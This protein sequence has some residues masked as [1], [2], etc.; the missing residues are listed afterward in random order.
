MRCQYFHQSRFPTVDQQLNHHQ[1]NDDL[2]GPGHES[3]H[4][5]IASISSSS[6][7]AG[8]LEVAAV[9]VR[10]LAGT[11]VSA[12]FHGASDEDIL[13]GSVGRHLVV[14]PYERLELELG[15]ARV[16]VGVDH[17]STSWVESRVLRASIFNQDVASRISCKGTDGLVGVAFFELDL[18]GGVGGGEIPSDIYEVIYI[19]RTW[20]VAGRVV[21]GS[22][23]QTEREVSLDVG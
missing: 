6:A 3:L 2:H 23:R 21:A 20:R 7:S 9:A 11:I 16:T 19:N 8:E 1:L 13:A 5:G 10:A 17:D 4:E 14:V 15:V 18:N 22:K 12:S